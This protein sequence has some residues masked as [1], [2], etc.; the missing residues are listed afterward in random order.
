MLKNIPDALTLLPINEDNKD[1]QN[2]E[3]KNADVEMKIT[4]VS[5]FATT[6]VLNKKIGEVKNKIPDVSGVIE[7]RKDSMT[8]KQKTSKKKMFYY[9]WL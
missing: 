4:S 3:E 8:L 2:L 5:V 7:K 9:C 1:K 6:A